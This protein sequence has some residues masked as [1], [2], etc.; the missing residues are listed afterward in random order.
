MCERVSNQRH[1]T[2]VVSNTLSISAI[3]KQGASPEVI[4]ICTH[5][6]PSTH[7]HHAQRHTIHI[8]QRYT[9]ITHTPGLGRPHSTNFHPKLRA[10]PR[11][12][13]DIQGH[14][15]FIQNRPVF[16]EYGFFH[17]FL[18]GGGGKKGSRGSFVALLRFGKR[19][20]LGMNGV[21]KGRKWQ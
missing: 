20:T 16:A 5:T 17:C 7:T 2:G 13:K 15:V 4:F 11:E 19:H 6:H 1:K 8:T 21:R 14:P 10:H 12:T 3:Q 9:H 18:L